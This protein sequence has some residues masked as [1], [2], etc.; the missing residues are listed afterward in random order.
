MC[1]RDRY[2]VVDLSKFQYKS[3]KLKTNEW[4][5]TESF[6]LKYFVAGFTDIAASEHPNDCFLSTV[7]QTDICLFLQLYKSQ[8]MLV[9]HS[10]SSVQDVCVVAFTSLFSPVLVYHWIFLMY[11]YLR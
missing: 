6:S 8:E 7:C 10:V 3:N 4:V 11:E 9:E 1:I 2:V 5:N